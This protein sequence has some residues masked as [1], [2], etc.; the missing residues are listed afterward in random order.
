VNVK[1]QSRKVKIHMAERGG[2]V[3]LS[4]VSETIFIK[5]FFQ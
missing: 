2:L 5:D 4:P 1:L 3:Q